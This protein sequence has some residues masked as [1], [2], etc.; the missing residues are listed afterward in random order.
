MPPKKIEATALDLAL[1]SIKHYEEKIEELKGLEIELEK[2]KQ[3]S[4]DLQKRLDEA[5]STI[6]DLQK[7][8]HN[9]TSEFKREAE[10]VPEETKIIDKP[11]KSFFDLRRRGTIA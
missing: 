6:L 10:E 4:E 2:E 7:Q 3:R 9:K 1:K 8:A 11:P 5:V